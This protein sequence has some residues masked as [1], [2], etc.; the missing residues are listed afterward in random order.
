MIELDGSYMEGGG[1]IVRTALALST[2]T[3]N[4][5]KIEHIRKGRPV[6][7]LKA[8]HL[9]CIESLQNLCNASVENARFGSETITFQ[10]G[11]VIA[12]DLEIDIGTAGSIT[13]LMQSLLMPCMFAN[14]KVELRI[15]GGTDTKWSMP[16]DYFNNILI[17]HLQKFC[18]IKSSLLQRGYYPKGQGLVEIIFRPKYK[19]KDFDNF[20]ELAGCVEGSIELK[21]QGKLELIKGISHAS[22]NLEEKQVAERQANSAKSVLKLFNVPVSITSQYYNTA[23]SGSGITLW[24]VFSDREGINIENPVILGSDCL[25]E[26][27]KT[28]EEVGAEAAKKLTASIKSR[29]SVDSNLADNLVPFLAFGGEFFAERITNHTKTNIYTANKFLGDVIRVKNKRVFRI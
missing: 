3:G 29:A 5:F 24:A 6:P 4:S 9:K 23:S 25:G 7:G 8:Q 15:K 18:R 14:K 20:Q 12:K 10:P 11:P 28:A 19:L 27:R 2:V 17:P 26:L 22:K 13:L 21:Q 1:Q 16:V